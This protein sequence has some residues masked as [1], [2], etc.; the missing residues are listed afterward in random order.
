MRVSRA[1][2]GGQRRQCGTRK[3]PGVAL[4]LWII[5]GTVV[6]DAGVDAMFL[7]A[8]GTM[9]Q[10]VDHAMPVYFCSSEVQMYDTKTTS[11][12]PNDTIIQ[13][14][15]SATSTV[16]AQI[17]TILVLPLHFGDMSATFPTKQNSS[18]VGRIDIIIG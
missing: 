2:A 10:G 4:L 9:T 8:V 7:V 14:I 5:V 1:E 15:M 12:Y 11:K 18:F 16:F 3:G 13:Y 17:T 6:A